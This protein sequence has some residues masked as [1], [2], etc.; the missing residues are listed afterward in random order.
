MEI[1]HHTDSEEAILD[2]YVSFVEFD[3][4][5]NVTFVTSIPNAPN[6]LLKMYAAINDDSQDNQVKFIS[7]SCIDAYRNVV[8]FIYNKFCLLINMGEVCNLSII[9]KLMTLL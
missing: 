6:K 5:K 7:I 1:I 2:S 4:K 8:M 3:V 9:I